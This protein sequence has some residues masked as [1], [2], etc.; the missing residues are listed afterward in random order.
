[1]KK[2][3]LVAAIAAATSSAFAMEAMDESTLSETTGQAGITVYIAGDTAVG[4]DE[5]S[6]GSLRYTDTDGLNGVS[7]ATYTTAGQTTVAGYQSA[8]PYNNKGT[9]QITGLKVNYDSMQLD[10]DVGSTGTLASARTG[11]LLRQNVSNLSL[12]VGTISL[13]NGDHLAVGLNSP[14]NGSLGGIKLTNM[15]LGNGID[16]LITPKSSASGLVIT[17]LTNSTDMRVNFGYYDTDIT[18][19]DTL[20]VAGAVTVPVKAFG[21]K[22]TG[23]TTIDVVNATEGGTAGAGLKIAMGGMSATQVEIGNTN[24]LGAAGVSPTGGVNISGTDIGRIGINTLVV[25]ASTITIRGH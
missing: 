3:I 22:L 16:M 15:S 13:D 1:M 5:L 23:D 8:T 9:L 6:I 21:V 18:G 10:I 7:T 11:I 2:L 17:P 24:W 4:K 14:S 19:S 12:D 20:N 25:G